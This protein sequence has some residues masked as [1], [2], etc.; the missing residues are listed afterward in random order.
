MV[1]GSMARMFQLIF[2][3]MTGVKNMGFMVADV[4]QKDLLFI[5]DNISLSF[6]GKAKIY[7]LIFD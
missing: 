4:N 3:S 2:L 6:R 7:K 5:M 1:G